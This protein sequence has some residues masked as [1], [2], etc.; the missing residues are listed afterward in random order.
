[1]PNLFLKESVKKRKY[2]NNYIQHGFTL[3]LKNGRELSKCEVGYKVLFDQLMKPSLLKR[4]LSACH[5]EI[6]DKNAAFFKRMEFGVKKV[7][8]DNSCQ[9]NQIN[10]ASLRASCMFALRISQKKLHI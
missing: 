8:L 5:S 3:M 1:M 10:E 2:N 9:V 7:S 4:H 6:V